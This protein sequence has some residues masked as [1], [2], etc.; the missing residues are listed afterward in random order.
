M[1]MGN[2]LLTLGM[3]PPGITAAG[4]PAIENVPVQ[5]VVKLTVYVPASR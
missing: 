1:S 5:F 4:P 2:G 3:A